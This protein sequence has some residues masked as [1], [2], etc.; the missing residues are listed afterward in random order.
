MRW[1]NRQVKM[2]LDIPKECE[3]D[4]DFM[5]RFMDT[6]DSNGWRMKVGNEDDDT[7]VEVTI[8]QVQLGDCVIEPE[9][10]E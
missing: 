4:D 7:L 6:L 1:K 5:E 3:D 8:S 9:D 2:K 10:E